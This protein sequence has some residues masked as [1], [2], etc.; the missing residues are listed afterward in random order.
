NQKSVRAP[1]H[2]FCLSYI[3]WMQECAILGN[4]LKQKCKHKEIAK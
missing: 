4:H 2:A 1:I 3:E